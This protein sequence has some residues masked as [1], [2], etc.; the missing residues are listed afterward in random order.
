[1]KIEDMKPGMY[2]ISEDVVN[3]KSDRRKTDRNFSALPQ[4]RKGLR[5][6]V[7]IEKANNK[8]HPN[9]VT[10]FRAGGYSFYGVT[11]RENGEYNHPGFDALVAALRP[12]EWTDAE[13]IKVHVNNGN[14]I[15][16]RLLESKKITREDITKVFGE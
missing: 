12:V 1:M 9:R 3:P 14:F 6:C 8:L 16:E 4:W 5:V 15:L 11:G 13:W 2:E 10:I 7:E